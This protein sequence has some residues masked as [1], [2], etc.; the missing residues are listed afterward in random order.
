[1]T[2]QDSN[3]EQEIK[4][5]FRRRCLELIDRAPTT[6]FG[7]IVK[8]LGFEIYIVTTEDAVSALLCAGSGDIRSTL[9]R[10]VDGSPEVWDLSAVA[11]IGLPVLRQ[12]M[13]LD[14]LARA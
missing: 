9:Y 8:G 1:M 14:D 2:L 10:A 7:S 3:H 6:N 12:H 4:D 5:E 13:V 11:N